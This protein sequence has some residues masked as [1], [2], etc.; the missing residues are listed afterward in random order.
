[1]VFACALM[2]PAGNGVSAQQRVSGTWLVDYD[3]RI[4]REGDG[5]ERVTER[6]KARLE[7]SQRGDSLFGTWQASTGLSRAERPVRGTVE[8]SN[9]RFTTG[10]AEATINRNGEETKIQI[11]SEF[12][13]AVDGDSI[14]GVM[15]VRPLN[16]PGMPAGSDRKWD[17][18]R[19][20]SP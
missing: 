14:G 5:A 1:M 17:G 6:G 19:Q 2:L 15:T 13:G 9:V 18:R 10:P 4:A 16:G 7:L 8:G 12:S 20:T 11:V 3:M